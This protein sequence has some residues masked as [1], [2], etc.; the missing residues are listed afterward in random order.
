MLALRHEGYAL[1]DVQTYAASQIKAADLHS[2]N[3]SSAN[4]IDSLGNVDVASNPLRTQHALD[5]I[6]YATIRQMQ[7][8]GWGDYMHFG[9]DHQVTFDDSEQGRQTKDIY[10]KTY[11]TALSMAYEKK[12]EQPLPTSM[13]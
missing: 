1:G 5:D 11:N 6:K 7:N 12:Y 13:S 9:E 10:D 8:Q 2:A 3:A 4:A